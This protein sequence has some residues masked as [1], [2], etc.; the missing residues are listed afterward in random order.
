MDT[1]RNGSARQLLTALGAICIVTMGC[2]EQAPKI[3]TGQSTALELKLAGADGAIVLKKLDYVLTKSD[4][5]QLTGEAD[6]SSSTALGFVLGGLLPGS[7]TISISS[8]AT[9]GVTTCVGTSTQFNVVAATTTAVTVNMA[10]TQSKTKGSIAVDGVLNVCPVANNAPSAL[11]SEVVVGGGIVVDGGAPL[12]PDNG[13]GALTCSW[14]ADPPIGV[15]ASPSA[16]STIFNCTQAGTATLK[17]TVS[18]GDPACQSSGSV[19]VTCTSPSTTTTAIAL[20]HLDEGTGTIAPDSNGSSDG[21][22]TNPNWTTGKVNGAIQSSVVGA[23]YV[24]VPSNATLEIPGSQVSVEA[25]IYPFGNS[26]QN[27]GADAMFIA[28]KEHSDGQS[29]Y[30]LTLGANWGDELTF[31]VTTQNGQAEAYSHETCPVNQWTHVAGVYDGSNIML[32]VNGVLKTTAPQTGAIL[33]GPF[34]FWIGKYRGGASGDDWAYYGKI[35]EVAIYDKAL[36][37]TEVLEHSQGVL[38]IGQGL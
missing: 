19:A 9:D 3:E 14:T 8:T 4:G 22:V 27:G 17:L 32:Y 1:H 24:T 35:D 31:F 37:A 12:D 29:A 2:G 20:W 36:S 15:F 18:D 16:A 34:P 30:G 21:T 38:P 11:P 23:T 10:C 7:Y 33:N 13:P 5:S 28:V 26:Y 25:W 6:L